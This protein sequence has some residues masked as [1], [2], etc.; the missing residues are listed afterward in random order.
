MLSFLFHFITHLVPA[1][2]LAFPIITAAIF[3]IL[4]FSGCLTISEHTRGRLAHCFTTRSHTACSK[5]YVRFSESNIWVTHNYIWFTG[6]L[7]LAGGMHYFRDARFDFF[8][9]GTAEHN[10]S[11]H[12]SLHARHAKIASRYISYNTS[13]VLII[14]MRFRSFFIEHAKDGQGLSLYWLPF[15]RRYY[16]WCFSFDILICILALASK[17][18]PARAMPL[19][20]W[21]C[22]FT[23][24]MMNAHSN[25]I[26]SSIFAISNYHQPRL[27]AR[28]YHNLVL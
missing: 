25:G 4:E 27:P 21:L 9:H 15:K 17:L 14:L 24:D 22:R 12:A 28:R 13:L 3:I 2:I 18:S 6:Y 1:M 7:L 20:A 8:E 26:L 23:R 5:A 16:A 19:I 11:P 10:S